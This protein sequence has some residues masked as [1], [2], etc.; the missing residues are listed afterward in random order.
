MADQIKP[1][2]IIG[3]IALLVAIA[4]V[5]I[6]NTFYNTRFFKMPMNVIILLLI[7]YALSV[8]GM[9]LYT[10]AKENGNNTVTGLVCNLIALII[11]NLLIINAIILF[12]TKKLGGE[13]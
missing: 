12:F 6:F 11:S 5:L 2:I 13:K 10:Q 1:V 7:P 4:T 3:I 9:V 8:T